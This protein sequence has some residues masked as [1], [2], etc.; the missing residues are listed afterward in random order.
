MAET[1]TGNRPKFVYVTYIKS[2][3]EKVFQALTDGDISEKY[4]FGN[5]VESDWKVGGNVKFYDDGKL[6]HDDPLLAYDPPSLLS[7]SWR[8]LHKRFEDETPSRVTCT[9]EEIDGYVKL[10]L[11]HEDFMP[12]GKMMDAVSQGWPVV[13]SNLKTLMETGEVLAGLRPPSRR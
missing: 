11:V 9:L 6:V 4:W 10:T 5:R 7:Y 12:G 2:T 1:D 13:L 3:R 8:P